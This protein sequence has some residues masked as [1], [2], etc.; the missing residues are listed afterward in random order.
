MIDS[1]LVGAREQT[2]M[3]DLVLND[4]SL[5]MIYGGI[6]SYLVGVDLL[7]LLYQG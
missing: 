4:L 7:L 3:K 6:W 2:I 5:D 1:P